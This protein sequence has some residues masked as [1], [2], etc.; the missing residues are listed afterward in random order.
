MKKYSAL[1]SA[2]EASPS[3]GWQRA[4]RDA[5]PR[6]K[7]MTMTFVGAG[8]LSGRQAYTWAKNFGITSR[9]LEKG[10]LGGG[11]TGRQHDDS[12]RSNYACKTPLPADLRKVAVAV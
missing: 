4:W 7:R 10:W 11:N 1:P 3:H 2:R 12:I 5:Q 6:K 8:G 9:D